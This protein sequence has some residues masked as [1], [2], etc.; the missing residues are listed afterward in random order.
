[1]NLQLHVSFTGMLVMLLFSRQ[2]VDD[3]A[4]VILAVGGDGTVNEVAMLMIHSKAVLG[5]IPKGSGNGLARDPIFRWIEACL[6]IFMQNHRIVIGLL[7]CQ[8]TSFLL[9][10]RRRL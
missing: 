10:M 7:S 3:G 6:D 2:A 5:I 9:H 1:M 8:R 4:S